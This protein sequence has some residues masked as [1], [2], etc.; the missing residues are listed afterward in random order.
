[1]MVMTEL[2]RSTLK[3]FLVG[4]RRTLAVLDEVLQ[5]QQQER[6]SKKSL[7]FVANSKEVSVEPRDLQWFVETLNR[8]ADEARLCASELA[9][10]SADDDNDGNI[11]QKHSP[12]EALIEKVAETTI[13]VEVTDKESTIEDDASK[14]LTKDPS[15]GDDQ[16]GG[17]D[18]VEDASAGGISHCYSTRR[19]KGKTKLALATKTKPPQTKIEAGGDQSRG[20]DVEKKPC[21]DGSG[22]SSVEDA[23]KM[24]M[25]MTTTTTTTT[26]TSTTKNDN[27]PLDIAKT[28]S[29]T[30]TKKDSELSD[31]AETASATSTSPSAAKNDNEP[32][33]T[34]AADD[35]LDLSWMRDIP[36]K[37]NKVECLLCNKVFTRKYCTNTHMILKHS[38]S[39][40]VKCHV[41]G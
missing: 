23:G 36:T 35:F 15:V 6:E 40:G 17:D 5:Q 20:S 41:E 13:S 18:Q 11:S 28:T 39:G 38:Q 21:E 7:D 22:D 10:H 34:A 27:E 24:M 2:P 37:P 8:I 16:V 31:A 3:L 26:S 30:S 33:D 29:T 4:L 9:R 1:M 12:A 32:L 19:S 14:D 25:M